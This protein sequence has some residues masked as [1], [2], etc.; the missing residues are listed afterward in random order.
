VE[1]KQNQIKRRRCNLKIHELSV[2]DI[3]PYKQNPRDNSKAVK[4]VAESIQQFGFKVP[5]VLDKNYE[6]VAGH[7]RLKAALELGL[8]TVPCI[9]A[10]DLTD[11]QIKAFRLADNK[12]AEL[13]EWDLELLNIELEELS[14]LDLN[15]SMADF[16]FE[17]EDLEELET[18]EVEE[19]D[20]DTDE[21]LADIETPISQRG[22]IWQLGKHRLMCGDSTSGEDID[23]LMD[24]Q[25]ARF[26]FTDPPWNVALGSSNH[27]SWK[28]G[29]QILND[30]MTTEEFKEFMFNVFKNLSLV[31]EPGCMTYVVMSAQEWGNLM[32]T[33]KEAGFHWSSTIIWAKDT[34]VLSRKDYH[35]QYEPIWYGWLDGGSR[36]CPL[37]DRKQSDVW[38]IPRP[39]RSDAHPTMKP[40]ELVARAITNSSRKGDLVL[41]LFG[42]S[43]TSILAAEQ[44]DRVCHSMELDPK[45]ADVIAK[46]YYHNFPENEIKL[47]GKPVNPELLFKEK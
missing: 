5:I 18:K 47:N 14:K 30:S 35:T 40:I 42:G 45:Y 15:F 21:A 17:L 39:K 8:T 4:A 2:N 34:L 36:L 25:K 3:K 1:L 46:R 24:G 10:D 33:L 38:E 44:T 6:I 9:I 22:D 32:L 29:R 19:D 13:A 7:T 43:G 27:P 12:A 41:D 20:F 28:P 23:L 26:V 37:D 16:G 31:C 11:A